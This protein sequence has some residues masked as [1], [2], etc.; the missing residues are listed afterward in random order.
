MK[1]NKLY[2]QSLR[3][4]PS[5]LSGKTVALQGH[6]NSEKT[7]RLLVVKVK[8]IDYP[9]LTSEENQIINLE[10]INTLWQEANT[11]R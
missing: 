8:E 11:V 1:L 10:S 4:N 9:L 7:E 2:L 3:K 6:F 5:M